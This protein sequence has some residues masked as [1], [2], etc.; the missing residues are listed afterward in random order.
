MSPYL[1]AKMGIRYSFL[2]GLFLC[3]ISVLSAYYIVYVDKILYPKQKHKYEILQQFSEPLLLAEKDSDNDDESEHEHKNGHGKKIENE[4][5]SVETRNKLKFLIN[6][7]NQNENEN[8]IQIKIND[9]ENEVIGEGI[10]QK[11]KSEEIDLIYTDLEENEVFI[12]NENE[13]DNMENID[14]N[15]ILTIDEKGKLLTKKNDN[16]DEIEDGSYNEKDT[17]FVLNEILKKINVND[18]DNDN[19]KIQKE[20]IK[21]FITTLSP[22]RQIY[23][24]TEKKKSNGHSH[25]DEREINTKFDDIDINEGIKNSKKSIELFSIFKF[26]RLFWT[27]TMSSLVVYGKYM[28]TFMYMYMYTYTFP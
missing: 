25:K 16:I 27:L 11:E 5:L 22:I 20:E 15:E 2:F 12:E 28:R 9:D 23:E 4:V 21:D 7:I 19:D 24:I 6:D 3:N 13:N 1:A 8:E 18:N 10:E 17:D 14:K 26:S